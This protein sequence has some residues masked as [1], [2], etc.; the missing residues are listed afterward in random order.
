VAHKFHLGS[1]VFITFFLKLIIVLFL[2][3]ARR[4]PHTLCYARLP[5]LKT[6]GSPKVQV[7]PA[8]SKA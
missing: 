3:I 8:Y 2:G 6:A 4:G 7:F 5:G 1:I